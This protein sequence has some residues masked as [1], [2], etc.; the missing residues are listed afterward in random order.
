MKLTILS[1]LL[2]L[3]LLTC[4]VAS[5][6]DYGILDANAARFG[7]LLLNLMIAY[8]RP[9][10]GDAAAVQA[11]IEAIEAADPD[12]GAIAR[13]I[14]DHWNRVYLSEYA[15]YVYGGEEV[16]T[17]LS[18][19]GFAD[20]PTHAI[21]VLGFE[22]KD[23]R[24]TDELK[25]RCDAAAAVAK[26][27]PSALIL[28]SGGA[29][30]KNNPQKHTEAGLMKDYLV[31]KRGID[32]ARI[33]IDERAMTTLENAENTFEMMRARGIHTMTVVTSTY[34]QRWGQAIYNAMAA[35]YRQSAGYDV[36][37]IGNYC[38]EIKPSSTYAHD[39]RFAIRQ[40]AAMLNL[41]DEVLEDM[42]Q[43]FNG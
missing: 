2:A 7:D 30:G 1:L 21:V 25:G 15:L 13:A 28:C 41:P 24:M 16:A 36:Q 4:G 11:D 19:I 31:N 6:E 37:I 32:A 43:R 8:E 42:K 29:T 23:G 27:W 20:S 9:A 18:A 34:H 22:L 35:I 10:E 14:A 33:L 26:Y 17:A 12:D 40:L 38:F 3:A 39:D 5:A